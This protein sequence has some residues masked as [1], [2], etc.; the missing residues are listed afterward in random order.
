MGQYEYE[1]P[2]LYDTFPEGFIWGVATSAY[3][4]NGTLQTFD[5]M[6]LMSIKYYRLK[7]GGTQMG[8]VLISGTPSA[9]VKER[10]KMDQMAK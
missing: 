2:L 6:K 5:F 3:Q 1:E 10:S 4:V 9:N 7:G 8:R